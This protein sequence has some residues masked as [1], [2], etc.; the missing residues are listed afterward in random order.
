MK[1]ERFQTEPATHTLDLRAEFKQLLH[2][3]FAVARA[4]SCANLT[5]RPFI[6]GG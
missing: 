2:R 4:R 6:M 5:Q 3:G 1:R